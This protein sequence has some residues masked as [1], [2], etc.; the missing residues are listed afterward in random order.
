MRDSQ[1]RN[2]NCRGSLR[3]VF[4]S[5]RMHNESIPSLFFLMSQSNLVSRLEA[6]AR[7]ADSRSKTARLR[8]VFEQVEAALDAGVSRAQV[9]EELNRDGFEMTLASFKSA[10]QRIRKENAASLR[11]VGS[12]HTN[13]PAGQEQYVPKS[14]DVGIRH[15][16][17][18]S[19]PHDWMQAKLTPAQNR[20][21]TPAQRR[22]RTDAQAAQFFPNRFKPESVKP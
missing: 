13:V 14:S 1:W 19:L 12:A 15:S 7:S 8:D 16:E 4:D 9:L 20:L 21:L 6:L 10:L 2:S 18:V 22:A 11:A 3:L 17:P 5:V